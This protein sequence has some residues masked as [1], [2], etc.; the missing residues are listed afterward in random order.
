MQQTL[1]L[2]HSLL[3]LQPGERFV[4]CEFVF[5]SVSPN[6]LHSPFSHISI[7]CP[8][9]ITIANLFSGKI[10]NALNHYQSR[11]V[12]RLLENFFFGCPS[13]V[14]TGSRWNGENIQRT[15]TWL[16]V[17]CS[18]FLVWLT[19]QPNTNKFKLAQLACSHLWSESGWPLH[20]RASRRRAWNIRSKWSTAPNA[21]FPSR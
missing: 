9:C 6:I 5:F 17:G 16:L 21:R 7:S 19:L 18:V 1:R 2:A 4:V 8:K 3:I 14:K 15:H 13:L 20:R 12:Y 10:N 11:S